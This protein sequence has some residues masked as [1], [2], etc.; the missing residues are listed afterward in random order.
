MVGKPIHV[1][2]NVG[3]KTVFGR[4][5]S[6]IV[7]DKTGNV[8]QSMFGSKLSKKSYKFKTLKFSK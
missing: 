4:K 8:F 6:D 7:R 5:V 3:T 1:T 2:Q